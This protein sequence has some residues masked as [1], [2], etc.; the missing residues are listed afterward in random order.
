MFDLITQFPLFGVLLTIASFYFGQWIYQRTNRF[1][2][3]QPVV[4]GMVLVI[5]SLIVFDIPY[6]RY[7][8]SSEM[9]HLLLGPATVALAIPL[10]QHAKRIRELLL[11]V[12][13][14]VLVGGTFTVG[15]AVGIL[16][17]FDVSPQ[18]VISMTTKSITT[19]IA[20]IVSEE[21][22]GVPALSAMFVLITGALGAIVAIPML[23]WFRIHDNGVRGFT[24]GLTSH[25]IG[26]ARAMEENEECAAFSALAMGIMGVATAIILPLIMFWLA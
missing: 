6:Q 21:I 12:M 20:M 18:T 25:A 2:P 11:P 19:P 24:L 9:L 13:C 14:T 1:A 10:F 16:W 4:I 22:G 15:V 26:T 3:F 5:G 7:Y 17:L 23:N 8:A